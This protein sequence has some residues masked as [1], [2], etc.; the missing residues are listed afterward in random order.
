MDFIKSILFHVILRPLIKPLQSDLINPIIIIN[1]SN[2][3]QIEINPYSA[4]ILTPRYL[5]RFGSV[6]VKLLPLHRH[7]R[8]R[9][10]EGLCQLTPD[11]SLPARLSLGVK[12]LLT[13]SSNSGHGSQEVSVGRR[14]RR[15]TY[16]HIVYHT[17]VEHFF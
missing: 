16:I 10:L 6:V 13:A 14:A 11:F 4:A 15:S 5:D 8:Q 1:L 3:V 7:R 17:T 9:R 2:T 12:E